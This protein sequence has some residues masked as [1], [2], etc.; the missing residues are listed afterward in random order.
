MAL[1]LVRGSRSYRL[2]IG[3]ALLVGAVVLVALPYVI[4]SLSGIGTLTQLVAFA[5][6]IL[7]LSLLIGY[8]GQISLGH[9]A[10]VGLGGYTTMILVTKQGWPYLATV[11]VAFVLCAIAGVIIG[12]PALR[13]RGLYLATVTLSIA[14]LFPV[15]VDKF[16][17]LT[18]GPNGLFAINAMEAPDWFFVNPYTVNGPAIDRYY[19]VLFIAVIMFVIAYNVVHSRIGRAMQSVRDAPFGAAAAGVRVA[20]VKIFSFAMSAAFGGVAG[21]LLVIQTPEVSDSRFDLNMSIFLLVALIAGGSASV[22]GAIPG[23]IIYT[24]LRIYIQD[25]S[26]SQ[27][28]ISGPKGQQ[29]VGIISGVL[30]LAFIFLLPGGVTD[31]IKRLLRKVIVIKE[32][33]PA[34]WEQYRLVP[35]TPD[36]VGSELVQRQTVPSS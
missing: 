3:G 5:V 16:D 32:R 20:R 10:F 26:S 11:P 21:S 7:G 33:P 30:L 13:I 17:S 19:A 6:A 14:A 24:T 34:G 8:T 27:S 1:T 35:E 25:W 4:N 22:I 15:L 29:L 23:A 12:M 2:T 18:G 9:S 36:S 31:G 28:W